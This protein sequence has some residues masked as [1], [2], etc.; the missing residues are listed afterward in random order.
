[1]GTS[2]APGMIADPDIYRAAK[3]ATDQHSADASGGRSA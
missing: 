3:L 2:G 1:M